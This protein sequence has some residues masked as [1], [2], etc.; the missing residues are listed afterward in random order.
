MTITYIIYIILL[1]CFVIFVTV[2]YNITSYSLLSFIKST[3]RISN[4]IKLTKEN[5]IKFLVQINIIMFYIL[6]LSEIFTILY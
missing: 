5:F 6:E 3:L 2:T 1:L 4:S